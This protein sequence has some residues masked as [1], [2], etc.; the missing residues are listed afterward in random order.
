[1]EAW[2]TTTR[3]LRT[4]SA[5]NPWEVSWVLWHTTDSDHFYYFIVK[6][7]GWEL[8]KKDPAYPGGQRFLATGSVPSFPIGQ[9]YRI[10]IRQSAETITVSVNDLP[11]TTFADYERP[12]SS[13][14]IGMY[15]EDAE[16]YFDNISITTDSRGKGKKK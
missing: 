15:S 9:W 5:A 1:M 6:P 16:A 4:G 11:I 2:T 13:G 10:G 8:G 14:R 7:N 3:Q 12:Y